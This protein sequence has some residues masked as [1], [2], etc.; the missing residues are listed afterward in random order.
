MCARQRSH[1]LLLR[2]KNLAQEKAAPLSV[3]L[4]FAPGNLRCSVQGRRGRTPFVHF[5]LFGQTAA[6][7]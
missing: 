4:R 1:L 6:A 5:A 2:Q 3:T 7:S